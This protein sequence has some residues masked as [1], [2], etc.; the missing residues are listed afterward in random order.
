MRT[1]KRRGHLWIATA[2]M[3][4]LA[5]TSLAADQTAKNAYDFAVRTLKYVETSAKRPKLAARLKALGD[6]AL[7]SEILK[8]RREIILSHPALAFDSLLINK[9][10]I[11]GRRDHMVDHYLG[12]FSKPG[13]GLVILKNWKTDPKQ[14]F[15]TKDHLPPG[16][17][18][19]PDLS[20]DAK[21]AVFAF[22]DHRQ[23]NALKRAFHLYEIALDSTGLRQ[24]TG[25]SRD[26]MK[27]RLGR[28]TQII[29]DFDPCYLPDGGIA[30]TSTRTM[31]SV[32]CANYTRYN[33]AFVLHRCAG[34]GSKIRAL[35]FGE[36]N[37][38]DPALR[39]DG[40][41]VYTRW[42]YINRNITTVHGL[43]TTSP[44]GTGVEHFFG[45][46]TIDPNVIVEA[47]AIPGSRKVVASAVAH[48]RYFCGTVIVIDPAKGADG[49]KPLTRVTPEIAFPERR[50]H[51]YTGKPLKPDENGIY[52][53][54]LPYSLNDKTLIASPPHEPKKAP[55]PYAMPFPLTEDLFLLAAMEKKTRKF[56]IYLI[57]TLGGRELIFS[58]PDNN[59]KNSCWAP[60]PIRPRKKPP[61]R[62]SLVSPDPSVKDGTFFIQDVY[63]N[64]FDSRGVIKRG[65]VK[66]MRIIQLLDQPAERAIPRGRV[67]FELPKRILGTVPV[68]ANGSVA[69][70]APAGVPMQFQLIDKNAMAVMTMRSFVYLHPG[71]TASCVGCHEPKTTAPPPTLRGKARIHDITPPPWRT[72]EKGMS[73]SRTIQPVLDRFCIRCHGLDAKNPMP[74]I[75]TP[76]TKTYKQTGISTDWPGK[77]TVP[78]T[79]G[80][81]NLL[82]RPGAVAIAQAYNENLTSKPK[83]YFAHAGKLAGMLLAGHPDKKGKPKVQ[84]DP[85]SLRRIIDWLD[86]N[87]PFAGMY[88][89]NRPENRTIDPA[90]EKALREH[91]KKTF[92]EKLSAQPIAA[93]VNIAEPDAS[94]ILMAPLAKSAGGWGQ[95][96]PAWKSTDAPE[97]KTMKNLVYATIVFNKYKDIAGTCGR[98][99]KNGCLCK[100]CWIREATTAKGTGK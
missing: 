10:P 74:L 53:Y 66:A 93:L 91:I 33:P 85:P 57:D 67:L 92:G 23:G 61:V 51:S 22:C 13:E 69:F 73:Y 18:T 5:G 88:S 97:Y 98:G 49:L 65:S 94:R 21:K 87:A 17:I 86:L 25:D 54:G 42:E 84:L 9:R 90:G 27:G 29:E 44:D 89:F 16:T 12:R 70:R 4:W 96:N 26:P 11:S 45:N 79:H 100:A 34:D 95:L 75:A 14:T 52:P 46:N 35:S 62:A 30:F 59:N 1:T 40:R 99:S 76:L 3:M 8:L 68:D 63:Q 82:A 15:I 72:Y 20:F 50:A 39:S 78:A 31:A 2:F 24:L 36:L 41:L 38:Y 28:K 83:D 7:T 47:R 37:E 80:Y 32:R 6:A 19:H 77:I 81:H 48:H 60:I 64:R 55:G 56:A 58:D 43:W 71:E